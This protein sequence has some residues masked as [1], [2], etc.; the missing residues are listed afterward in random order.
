MEF[1][2][3]A[4]KA[5]ANAN[6]HGVLFDYA[7]SVFLDDG[8]LDF[9]DTRRDYQ[10]ERRVAIGEIDEQLFVIVYTLREKTI[11]IISAR[12]ANGRERRQYAG[13]LPS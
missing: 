9:E 6:K 10:E 2:W 3:D 1:E 4:L 8:R 13:S 11:R 12:K 7:V 5:A